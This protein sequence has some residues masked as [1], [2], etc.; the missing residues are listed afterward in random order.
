MFFKASLYI[1]LT[2][3]TIG[4]IYKVSKWFTLSIDVKNSHKGINYSFTAIKEIFSVIFGPKIIIVIKVFILDVLL[5]I[6][7]FKKSPLTW[8]MHMLIFWGFTLLLLMHALDG[9]ITKKLFPEYYPTLNPFMFLRDLFA[10]LAIIGIIIACC[11]RLLM[12]PPKL[13]TNLS[14]SYALLI[15]IIIIFS[16]VFLEGMKITS[17]SSYREMVDNYALG[18]KEELKALEMYWV[19]NY[20]IISPN[21]KKSDLKE[22]L[23]DE[24]MVL[25]EEMNDNCISCHSRPKAAFIGNMFAKAVSPIALWLDN[26]GAITFMWYIHILA[27]FIGLAYLPFEKMFHSLSVPICLITNA[28]MDKKKF[29]FLDINAKQIMELDAC[30]HCGA[31]SKECSLGAFFYLDKNILIFPSEKIRY[32]KKYLKNE[33]LDKK[34]LRILQEGIYLCTS[35]GRCTAVCPSGIDIRNLWFGVKEMIVNE[36]YPEPLMLSPLSFYRY[37]LKENIDKKEYDKPL[38]KVREAISYNY[39]ASCDNVLK[40]P[41]FDDEFKSCVDDSVLSKT[42]SNCFSCKNCTLVCPVVRNYENPIKHLDMFPHQIIHALALGLKDIVLGSNMIW[43]CTTC[44][45][46]QEYCP[47]CVKITDIFYK[48]KNIAIK[49][50]RRT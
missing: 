40:I 39:D 14:D 32:L 4:V 11:R 5:Q 49:E 6:R 16:G 12:T 25:G 10:G 33:K 2:I 23:D 3:F 38:L 20:N 43:D 37:S 47:Q 42:Y 8:V 46:C 19:K 45:L 24:S 9:I 35:C 21:F 22:S 31:C 30:V 27:C 7:M 17:Y 15:L 36:E 29:N 44:Y 50:I 28:V 26:A 13:F 41:S 1:S 34:N 18:D 48:L